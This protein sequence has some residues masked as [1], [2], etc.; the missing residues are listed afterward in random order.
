MPT[1][2]AASTSSPPGRCAPPAEAS[3]GAPGIR[4]TQKR[5]NY[6]KHLRLEVRWSL[7]LCPMQGGDLSHVLCSACVLCV[8]PWQFVETSFEL[9]NNYTEVIAP[10]DVATYGGLCALASFD[11]AELKVCQASAAPVP[12]A[13]HSLLPNTLHDESALQSS[14]GTHT[15][16]HC[17]LSQSIL[18]PTSGAAT[19][20]A[21]VVP[22]GQ[23]RPGGQHRMFL[24]WFCGIP[25]ACRAK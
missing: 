8:S 4:H 12:R 15:L 3:P 18:L 1:S 23:S 16:C 6:N 21:V 5:H 10:Q 14:T 20:A 24:S 19:S 9:G 13:C 7:V 2:R 11:R 22:A 17:H 25:W